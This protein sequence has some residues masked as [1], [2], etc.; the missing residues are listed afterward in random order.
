MKLFRIGLLLAA[1][2]FATGCS[3]EWSTEYAPLQPDVAKAWR[4]SDVRVSV[5]DTL[6]T[7][8]DNTLAPDYDVV[9]HGEPQG[10][11]RAQVA[12]IMSE[13]IRR[14]ATG[15]RGS[16]P[17]VLEA[18]VSQFHA[19]TPAAVA[20]APSA[21]HDIRYTIQVVDARTGAVLSPP[22]AIK[23]D[24]P[25]FVGAAAVAAAVE[26]ETQN[27]RITRHIARV[28]A[29]WLGLGPDPRTT[30]RSFGR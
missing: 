16:I 12:A 29:G 15:L 10:D 26:G 3:R 14:G 27:V 4:L 17:V 5:P 1:L 6:T 18:Q 23:A 22:Q 2:M 13:G 25:A 7:S 24:L 9:W 21:V 11:R 19:V 30:F 8:E 20:T 28:T